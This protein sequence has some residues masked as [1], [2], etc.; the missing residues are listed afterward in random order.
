MDNLVVIL[1]D[2]VESN[3]IIYNSIK[4]RSLSNMNE[5]INRISLQYTALYSLCHPLQP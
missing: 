4:H 1:R 5:S 2:T 3:V